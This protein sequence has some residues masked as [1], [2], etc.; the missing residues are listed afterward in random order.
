VDSALHA[1][2]TALEEQAG[3]ELDYLELVDPNTFLPI[4]RNFHGPATAIVAALV[5]DTRLIDNRSVTVG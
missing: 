1:A 3:I 2:R 4:A 5:G